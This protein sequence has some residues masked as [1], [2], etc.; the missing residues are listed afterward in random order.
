MQTKEY[1]GY[2]N[3]ETWVVALW[4]DND[5]GTHD[6]WLEIAQETLASCTDDQAKINLSDAL[7]ESH[8]ESEVQGVFADLLNAA[9]SEVDWYDIAENLLVSAKENVKG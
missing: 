2:T 9:M 7:K 3:Y 6:Y 1:N 8:E 5:R 4:L